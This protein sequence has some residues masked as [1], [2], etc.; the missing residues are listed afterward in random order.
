M[1]RMKAMPLLAAAMVLGGAAVAKDKVGAMLPNGRVV[2]AT[3]HTADGKDAG[4]ATAREVKG[5]LRISLEVTGLPAG[6]HGAHIHTIGKCDAP[7]FASAGGHW[8][9]TG[10]QHGSMNPQGPHQGDLP[11]LVVGK[12][13]KGVL[14]INLP[15]ATMDGLLD[16]D[17]SAIVIHANVDDLKTD[18][19]G[20]SG[21]RLAC[22]VFAGQ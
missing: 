13:G 18:P 14:G 15:G 8:N 22:G 2:V 10:H 19:S 11:N 21:A 6:E 17:G 1:T 4:H 12:N 16:A 3:L 5:G 9:P 20:N 7:D